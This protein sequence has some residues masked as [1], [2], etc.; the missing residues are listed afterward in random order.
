MTIRRRFSNPGV[1]TPNSKVF[2]GATAKQWD[3]ALT[4]NMTETLARL[5]R[6]VDDGMNKRDLATAHSFDVAS[7]AK[8]FRR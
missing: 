3:E 1:L 5:K 2:G 4:G 7:S 8:L 6:L